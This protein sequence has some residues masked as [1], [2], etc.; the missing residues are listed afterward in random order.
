[1]NY[2]IER[3]KYDRKKSDAEEVLMR[4]LE[5]G[6]VK[7]GSDEWRKRCEYIEQMAE[8]ASRFQTAYDENN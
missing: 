6:R 1:M 2:L 5:S 4:M 7:V 8:M 3:K